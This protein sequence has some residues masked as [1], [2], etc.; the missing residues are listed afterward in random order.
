MLLC[1]GEIVC[2]KVKKDDSCDGPED[3]VM[4]FRFS[5]LLGITLSRFVLVL[6]TINTA[7]AAL[8]GCC[9]ERKAPIVAVDDGGVY[10]R[11]V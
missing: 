4:L 2:G 11:V 6:V 8:S 5:K 9:N 3:G 1:G 7:P 10:W